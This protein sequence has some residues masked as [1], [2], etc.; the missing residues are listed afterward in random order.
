MLGNECRS[1]AATQESVLVNVAS[2]FGYALPRKTITNNISPITCL[3]KHRENFQM[4]QLLPSAKLSRASIAGDS[5]A[6]KFDRGFPDAAVSR[7]ILKGRSLGV[8][9]LVLALAACTSP[10][11]KTDQ[12]AGTKGVQTLAVDAKQRVVFVANPSK[13]TRI[14][15]CAEPS[16]DALSALSA[17]GSG[18]ASYQQ[19]AANLALSEAESAA[20]IGLRTQSIQLLRDGMYRLCE[21][22]A[23]GALTAE[24]YNKQQRRYQNLM[25]SLLA[26]EQLTGA[27]AAGQATLG[28]GSASASAG[29]R[30]DEAAGNL[31]KANA[32]VADAQT[33]LKTA[34]DTLA[35]D[36]QACSAAADSTSASCKSVAGDATAVATA[37]SKLDEA[38][39]DQ[40]T[41][42]A[43]LASARAA[44]KA[45]AGGAK[46]AISQ[47]SARN[48]ITEAT[49][50]YIAEATR[51]IVS[52]TLLASF[53]QEE[54]A[55]FWAF[56]NGLPDPVKAA[57]FGFT[58]KGER[59][60][61]ASPLG[62]DQKE[63]EFVHLAKNCQANEKKLF[64][65]TKLFVPVYAA[66]SS[67]TLQVLGASSG[68]TLAS[69]ASP[70]RL[71]V[72]GGSPNYRVSP[73]PT[74]LGKELTWALE[75]DQGNYVL[76]ISRAK[77]G[78]GEGKTSVFVIDAN[79]SFV[80]VPITF[81][82]AALVGKLAQ[83]T[84]P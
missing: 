42:Q 24:E 18:G 83:N 39:Q 29:D 81:K 55:N 50:Q 32:A 79:N 78:S 74:E 26:I 77:G 11:H 19:I 47:P 76:Q 7:A 13:E 65:E 58:E 45:E 1:I 46:V 75:K 31:A 48:N 15:T 41:D 36:K 8:N 53:E 9:L 68:V 52:T 10:I 37:Q 38:Q 63:S 43:A 64:E 6:L 20:S 28:E 30:A 4:P 33:A 57:V 14:V 70:V 34:Q 66:V 49:A 25:L 67:G 44:V 54:C 60:S 3:P 12:F 59:R 61:D 84:T 82:K 71:F 27:V 40:K 69:E 62:G 21:G 5:Q 51:T 23:A 16:P 56:A 80:E 72:V 73:V 22:F 2:V 35:S 17:A